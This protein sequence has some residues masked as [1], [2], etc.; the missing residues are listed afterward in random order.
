MFEDLWKAINGPGSWGS[1]PW[2]WALTFKVHKCNIDALLA[3]KAA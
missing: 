2:V 1:N 3:Q